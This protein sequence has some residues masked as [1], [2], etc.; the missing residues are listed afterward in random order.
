MEKPRIPHES[1]VDIFHDEF[2]GGRIRVGGLL[3][4]IVTIHAV[5]F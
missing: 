1:I 3:T 5:K 2:F 4:A